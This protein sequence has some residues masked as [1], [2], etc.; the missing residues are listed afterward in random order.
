VPIGI[1]TTEFAANK[2]QEWFFQY[3]T[4]YHMA[5]GM[6]QVISYMD[7]PQNVFAKVGYKAI[8]RG[9]NSLYPGMDLSVHSQVAFLQGPLTK[10]Q[11]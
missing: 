5:A 3:H 11:E 8:K 7:M 10:K 6:G 4:L 9:D 2:Q 1:I